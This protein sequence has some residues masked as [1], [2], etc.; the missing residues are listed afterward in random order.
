MKK[1]PS[2]IDTFFTNGK[3]SVVSVGALAVHQ[4][5]AATPKPTSDSQKYF[6]RAGRPFGS[7][8]LILM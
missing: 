1:M 4:I 7:L 3:I 6:F 5:S 2:E 8:Y